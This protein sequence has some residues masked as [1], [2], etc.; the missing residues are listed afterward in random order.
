[1][2]MYIYIYIVLC[3]Y[4]TNTIITVITM[5][6]HNIYIYIYTYIHVWARRGARSGGAEALG[7]GRMGSMCMCSYVHNL[8]LGL[9]NPS[10]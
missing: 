2:H 5:N 3:V 4:N 1:M 6:I 7:C 9:I 8:H 10:H